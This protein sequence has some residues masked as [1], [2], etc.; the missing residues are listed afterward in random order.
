MNNAVFWHV[1][2]C[3][4]CKD[5]RFEE[6]YHLHHQGDKNGRAKKTLAITSKRSTLWIFVPSSPI[7]VTLMMVVIRSSKHR[8]VQESHGVTSQKT[9]F[10]IV[11]A[12]K[13]SNLTTTKI[14]T[15]ILMTFLCSI[16]AS[17]V[18]TQCMHL[19]SFIQRSMQYVKLYYL[20][21]YYLE[22]HRYNCIMVNI[23]YFPLRRLFLQEPHGVTS[24]K[25]A[26]FRW[27]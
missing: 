8:F 17:A 9:P 4:S 26:F 25:T 3:G 15:H 5:R 21:A 22:N 12:V 24:Q 18:A 1:T 20:V 11:T 27:S 10:F 2:P 23:R 13:T 6:M 14:Y 16:S 19:R 7:L